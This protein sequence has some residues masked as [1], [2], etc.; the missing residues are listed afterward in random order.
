MDSLLVKTYSDTWVEVPSSKK[1]PDAAY[2]HHVSGRTGMLLVNDTFKSRDKNRP[3]NQLRPS[4]IAWQ[5]FVLGA[6]KDGVRPSRLKNIV[7][8]FVLNE[9]T[10]HVIFETARTST[11]TLTGT[12]GYREFTDKD[13]GFRAHLGSVLG[14]LA[15]H[16]LLD[17]KAEIDYRTVDRVLLLARDD[18]VPS[19][20]RELARTFGIL[21][22]GPKPL[23]KRAKSESPRSPVPRS[24]KRRRLSNSIECIFKT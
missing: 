22:S 3:E 18:L 20:E 19:K 23:E 24:T 1:D 21:L 10:Q 2:C 17:H 7:M 11:S 14:K 9:N 5:S 4:E 12:N 13:D 16:M 8:N 15:M 6:I